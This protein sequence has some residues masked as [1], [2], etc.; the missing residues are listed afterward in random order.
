MQTSIALPQVPAQNTSMFKYAVLLAIV[1][2]LVFSLAHAGADTTAV[3][4]VWDQLSGWAKGAPGKIIALLSFM[5][6]I[7]FGIVKP[8]YTNAIGSII[9]CLMMANATDIIENFLAMSL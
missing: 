9:F 2:A 3:D 6:A 1:V 8:N 5:S 4:D 7:W